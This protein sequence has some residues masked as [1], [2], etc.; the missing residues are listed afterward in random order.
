MSTTICGTLMALKATVYKAELSVSD[1][2]RSYYATHTIT[3]AR[4]PSETEERLMIRLLA[5]VMH[6]HEALEFGRG[7]STEDEP[8]LWQKDQTG[9]IQHW[10]EVGLPDERRL[11]RATGRAR[12]VS[13]IAYG[14]R[15]LDV[16]WKKNQ[17]AL[18]RLTGLTVWVLP[19]DTVKALGGLAARNMELQCVIQDGQVV[20]S[21]ADTYLNIEP[22][23]R[24]RGNAARF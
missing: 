1:I 5:F 6:A 7:L 21:N 3:L 13:L 10:I 22:E 16:W 11:R 14:Q 12:R 9:E 20:L 8:D 18:S 15:S 19:D 2:D 4:H 17:A 24:Q 23:Q